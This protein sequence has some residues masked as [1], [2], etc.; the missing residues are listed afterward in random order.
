MATRRFIAAALS[1]AML[2]AA[3]SAVHVPQAR[4][5]ATGSIVFATERDG[6]FELSGLPAPEIYAMDASGA[7]LTRLTDNTARDENPALSPDGSKI[8]FASDR[9]GNDEIYVMDVSGANQTRLTNDPGSDGRASWSP[10]GNQIV[11][12]SNRNGEQEI[13]VMDA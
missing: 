7:G 8:A 10:D 3:P 4:A 13:F 9:D 1:A 5:V 12:V 2:A 6:V 11:F